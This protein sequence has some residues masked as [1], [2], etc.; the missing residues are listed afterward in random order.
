MVYDTNSIAFPLSIYWKEVSAST[1]VF[2]SFSY[3]S[4][5]CSNVVNLCSQVIIRQLCIYVN[6]GLEGYLGMILESCDHEW[7]HGSFSRAKHILQLTR[8]F[9][10]A[11]LTVFVLQFHEVANTL[12]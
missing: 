9:W 7:D 6:V 2:F 5:M 10:N 3:T 12:M 8:Y 11:Y 4:P 1:P